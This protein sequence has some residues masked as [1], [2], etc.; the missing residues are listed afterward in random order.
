[1]RF[2]NIQLCLFLTAFIAEVCHSAPVQFAHTTIE[3]ISED[4]AIVPGENFDLA[5]RFDLEE[6]WHIYWKNPGASGLGSEIYW[7]LPEGIEAAEIKWPSPHRIE[8]GGLTN[9]GYENEAVF[10]VTMKASNALQP[11]Q[12]I[13][14]LAEI[15]WLICKDV[16]LP[17]DAK[18][19]ISLPVDDVSARSKEAPAFARARASQP[20]LSCPWSVPLASVDKVYMK[21]R[22]QG[23]DLP[24]ELYFYADEIGLIDPNAKQTLEH[25][26]ADS[27]HL[28]LKLASEHLEIKTPYIRGIL[29]SPLGSWRVAVPT[30]VQLPL[31]NTNLKPLARPVGFEQLLLSLGL[32]GFLA[33]SF[34]GGVIL[35]IMPCV[36]PVLSL[37]VFSL[38]KHAG[39]ERV[40]AIRHGLVYTAGVVLS[41]LLLA[42]V[43]FSLR[44]IGERVGWGFQ[45]Q[46]PSFLVVLA[47]LFFIFGLNLFGVF[48]LGGRLVGADTSVSKRH[49]L[50]GSFAM[51]VLAAVVGAPCMG[52]LVAGVSGIAVQAD[53][54]TGLLIFGMLGFG[55]A[56]PFLFL[57]AFPGLVSLLPK[58]GAWME[59]F[60]KAMGFLL[61]AAVV[62]LVSVAGRQGGV[63][64]MS[65]LLFSLLLC[66]VA[67][68]VYGYWTAPHR[69]KHSRRIARLLSLVLIIWALIF[70]ILQAKAAYLYYG[71]VSDLNGSFSQWQAWSPERV[72]D[73]L[74]AGRPVF[75]DFTAS[76]CLI[77]Q[78]N[79]K[80]ALRT[81]ATEAL[82]ADRGIVALEADWTRHDPKITDALESYGRSGVPLYLFYTP[83]G[84][85]SVLA[86]N[87]T[88]GHVRDVVVDS[89]D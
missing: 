21:L 78:V 19:E 61:M 50:T 60:K 37:K 57:S 40:E 30:A 59:S 84:E 25:S 65:S 24:N 28:G 32:P 55:L 47:I 16:C 87:L 17:G 10:I 71:E 56:S 29:Q 75:V 69:S 48:E 46:S 35:N 82:F 72:E 44:A 66:A 68:W 49:D 38:L 58:P 52:P 9:Y 15:S 73:E 89:L 83:E 43:L 31:K 45:L 51:G 80:I 1:M 77:C 6:D 70:G 7:T 39:Q 42:T 33:L 86:Q 79:K 85:V 76:W 53:L 11:G 36:L 20:D 81:K 18:L 2:K 62:F 63:D 14:I 26:G 12:S 8:L 88:P 5:I 22:V 13:P 34:L 41:F 67:A 64:A 27:V 54:G 4:L 74:A 3:L 23:E